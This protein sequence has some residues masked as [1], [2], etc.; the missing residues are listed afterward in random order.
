MLIKLPIPRLKDRQSEMESIA[1]KMEA[2][3]EARIQKLIEIDEDRD[4]TLAWKATAAEPLKRSPELVALSAQMRLLVEL[5]EEQKPLWRDSIT[6]LRAAAV[7]DRPGGM[8][9]DAYSLAINELNF[10][11]AEAAQLAMTPEALQAAVDAAVLAEDWKRL[12]CLTVGRVDHLGQALPSANGLAGTPLDCLPLPGRDE[13]EEIFYKCEVAKLR[14]DAVMAQLSS[15]TAHPTPGGNLTIQTKIHV[16]KR[17]YENAV[18]QRE[19]LRSKLTALERW[20]A[21]K[22]GIPALPDFDT[23]VKEAMARVKQTG[24]E[25]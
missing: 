20:E 23:K 9:T 25:A 2:I 1:S 10:L 24:L 21:F 16:A 22:D 7:P 6:L 5:I 11:M 19:R 13:S 14:A 18:K 15:G 17:D 12:H 8:G 3:N 4:H